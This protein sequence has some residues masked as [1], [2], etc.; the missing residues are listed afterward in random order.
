MKIVC[1]HNL[2]VCTRISLVVATTLDPKNS[3]KTHYKC[4]TNSEMILVI[5]LFI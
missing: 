1:F 5:L 3:S 4:R 2:L